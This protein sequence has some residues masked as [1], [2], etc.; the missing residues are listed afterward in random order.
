M[1]EKL[2]NWKST[3]IGV[4][5]IIATL[6]GWEA[7]G[8]KSSEVYDLVLMIIQGFAGLWLIFGSKD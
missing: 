1:I 4:I 5:A 8:Q 3:I 6:A 7:V 2:K